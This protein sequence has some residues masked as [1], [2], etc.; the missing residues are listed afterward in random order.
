MVE[1][2]NSN[3]NLNPKK[4]K[5]EDAIENTN[6]VEGVYNKSKEKDNKTEE[7]K[8]TKS[9]ITLQQ[10]QKMS[11]SEYIEKNSSL[12]QLKPTGSSVYYGFE[13]GGGNSTKEKEVY[14]S[15]FSKEKTDSFNS[16][17]GSLRKGN[18]VQYPEHKYY[19]EKENEVS[20]SIKSHVQTENFLGNSKENND[21]QGLNKIKEEEENS[22][23]SSI[24]DNLNLNMKPKPSILK[25]KDKVKSNERKDYYGTEINENKAHK[26]AFIDSIVDET[27][28]SQEVKQNHLGFH[29]IKKVNKE[30]QEYITSLAV[31]KRV[32]SFKKINQHFHYHKEEEPFCMDFCVLF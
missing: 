22:K 28:Q 20:N 27:R 23:F 26:V 8:K 4:S 15:L 1:I 30:A 25:K 21:Y 13:T 6:L 32:K 10:G 24:I 12:Q 19:K 3:M 18:T 17:G 5:S 31:V 16:L 7:F 11:M 9:M 2:S 14:D 29:Y